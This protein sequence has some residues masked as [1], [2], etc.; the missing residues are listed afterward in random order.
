MNKKNYSTGAGGVITIKF[1]CP[2]NIK[3]PVEPEISVALSGDGVSGSGLQNYGGG[4]Y[5]SPEQVKYNF[6][7]DSDASTGNHKIKVTVRF[8]YCNSETGVCKIATK[9]TNVTVK[10]K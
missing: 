1:K 4:D 10:V 9:T 6:S 7:V 3:I 5:L 8:G 2:S